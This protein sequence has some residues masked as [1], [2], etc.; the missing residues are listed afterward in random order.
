[1]GRVW[2]E[3]LDGSP[4]IHAAPW[5]GSSTTNFRLKSALR[6][7]L[8][9]LGRLALSISVR[10]MAMKLLCA[11]GLA[12]FPVC[13]CVFSPECSLVKGCIDSVGALTSTARGT[14]ISRNDSTGASTVPV[15]WC[16]KPKNAV[17]EPS[18]SDPLM[19]QVGTPLAGW[20]WLDLSK[21]R[22]WVKTVDT[23][24]V[25]DDKNGPTNGDL[26]EFPLLRSK[27]VQ[28]HF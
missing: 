28:L 16:S 2:R 14:G 22:G 19:D 11:D 21:P 12:E 15:A 1:M 18:F 4:E 27:I 26:K 20:A 17:V 10:P 13:S 7:F 6:G 23:P 24:A 9:R 3:R 8:Q 5:P 25:K